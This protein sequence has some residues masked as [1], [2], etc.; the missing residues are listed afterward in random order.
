MAD[1]HQLYEI[2]SDKEAMKYRASK[3]MET[4]ADAESYVSNQKLSKESAL[5]VRKGIELVN[6]NNTKE[7]IG[8]VMY[9]YHHDRKTE[10]EIGYSIGRQ[11][12]GKGYGKEIVKVLLQSL[13]ENNIIKDIIAWCHQD[14]IASINILEKNEFQLIKQNGKHSLYKRK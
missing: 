14:N 9:R 5:T 11:Y 7:L 6:T 2:Y 3:P 1:I 13:E 8:S 10:C 4:I 12:W